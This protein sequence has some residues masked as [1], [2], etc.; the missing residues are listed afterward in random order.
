M[1]TFFAIFMFTSLASSLRC[2]TMSSVI[3]LTGCFHDPANVQQTSSKL[4]ANVQLHYNI[5]QQTFSKLSANVQQTSSIHLLKV[6]WTFARSCKHPIILHPPM[7][8]YFHGNK[9]HFHFRARRS[10][11]ILSVRIYNVVINFHSHGISIPRL[12]TNRI[13]CSFRNNSTP[14]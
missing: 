9:D 13:C 14:L 8:I 3:S 12:L 10:F 11:P 7:R 1:S 4:P 6:C 5:W 2:C